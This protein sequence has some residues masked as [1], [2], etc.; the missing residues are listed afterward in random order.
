MGAETVDSSS[1][2]LRLTDYERNIPPPPR[3]SRKVI[4]NLKEGGATHA[5]IPVA[6]GFSQGT[7]S[8]KLSRNSEESGYRPK[9][10]D[11][12]SLRP[13]LRILRSSLAAL[14]RGVRSA[15]ALYWTELRATRNPKEL[16]ERNGS[17]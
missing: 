16:S 4:G 7:V 1:L 13:S 10:A 17:R 12:P 15:P 11:R 6:I 3:G 14:L 2:V 8:K 9:E 5:P